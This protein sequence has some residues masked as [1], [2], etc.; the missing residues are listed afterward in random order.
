MNVKLL[1]LFFVTVAQSVSSQVLHH[2]MLS[3]QGTSSTLPNGLVVKQTIGQQSAIGNSKTDYYVG[4]GFQQSQWNSHIESNIEEKIQTFV[5]PNPFIDLI[6]FEF[7]SS[8][9]AKVMVQIFNVAG[10]TVYSKEVTTTNNL[11][12][13]DLGYIPGGL[14][15]VSLS[16]LNFSYFT[17]IL[18]KI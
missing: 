5:Y 8:V 4:Q 3:A 9:G 18:K 7:S 16:A 11:V 1:L 17:K 2:Q 12:T 10:M 13:L 14:Y 15:L 6:N